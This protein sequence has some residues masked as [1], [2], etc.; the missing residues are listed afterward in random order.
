M[1]P[2]SDDLKALFATRQFGYCNLYDLKRADG[3]HF[4]YAAADQDI[5]WNGDVYSC[6]GEVGPFF[7]RGDRLA[8]GRWQ[9]GLT[10]NDLVFDVVPGDGV[11][12]GFDFLEAVKAGIFDGAE[13]TQLR[14]YFPT[15]SSVV[16]GVFTMFVGRVAP[17][18]GTR[19]LITFTIRSRTELLNMKLPR[20]LFQSGCR[21]VLFDAGCT[22]SKAG[23]ASSGAAAVGTTAIAVKANLSP[24]T[25]WFDLGAVKF[26]SGRNAGI[27]RAV[28]SYVGGTPGTLTLTSP[29]PAVPA[30]GDTFTAWPGCDL[31]QAACTAKFSNLANFGG[32]PFIPSP[33]TAV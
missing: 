17:V 20:N 10:V 27:S 16:T 8:K 26:T 22:L 32:E 18:D 12:G 24:A 23:Y 2:M 5:T 29:L 7:E 30:V 1:R 4:R 19:S 14:A 9:R 3:T 11:I 25:G 28:K 15:G 33:E 13:C 6:G 21:H 31:T